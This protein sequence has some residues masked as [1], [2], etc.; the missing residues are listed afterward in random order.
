VELR[1]GEV[2]VDLSG[3]GQVGHRLAGR[4]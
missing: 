1:D 3:F 4:R 2:W